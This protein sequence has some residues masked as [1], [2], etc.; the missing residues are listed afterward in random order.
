MAME[1]APNVIESQQ[2]KIPRVPNI[3]DRRTVH[4][5]LNKV[6]SWVSAPEAGRKALLRAPAGAAPPG[7]CLCSRGIPGAAPMVTIKPQV[8]ILQQR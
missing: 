8:P 2:S 4:G 6:S 3:A 7:W 5:Q 1:I